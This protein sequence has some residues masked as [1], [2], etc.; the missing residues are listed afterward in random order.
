MEK[1]AASR[2][3]K[4]R[5][6]TGKKGGGEI[7]RGRRGG[8]NCECRREGPFAS[9]PFPPQEEHWTH[10]APR[11]SSPAGT[12]NI[13]FVKAHT[14][15]D[16][17][18]ATLRAYG[19]PPASRKVGCK[20]PSKFMGLV[21]AWEEGLFGLPPEILQGTANVAFLGFHR[22]PKIGI[23]QQTGS[24]AALSSRCHPLILSVRNGRELISPL[25]L[26]DRGRTRASDGHWFAQPSVRP[27]I[28]ETTN[29]GG[30]RPWPKTNR[31]GHQFAQPSRKQ[32]TAV[33]IGS[34][35]HRGNNEPR[36]F[37]D[38]SV[39]GEGGEVNVE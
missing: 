32:R 28:E 39:L 22:S 34:P 27:A 4:G 5:E 24:G 26:A 25:D 23:T 33:S 12:L 1:R 8:I 20:P 14:S 21:A 31:G 6:E 29:R 37:A 17:V 7:G 15:E 10:D 13:K 36:R 30:H 38:Q 18:H 16:G 11:E 9:S 2:E 3:T 19:A 35:S